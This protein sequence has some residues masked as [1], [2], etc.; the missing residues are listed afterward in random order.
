MWIKKRILDHKYFFGILGFL[1]FYEFIVVGQC[2]LWRVG[3]IGYAFHAVD[4]E[5]GFASGILPGAIY[6]FLM[7]PITEARVSGYLMV[8]YILFFAVVAFL[9]E[10]WIKTVD[11]KNRNLAW[12]FMFLFTTGPSTFSVYVTELGILEFYWVLFALLFFL[13]LSFRPLQF[14]IVPLCVLELLVNF[15]AIICIIPFF[16][17]LILFKLA[18]EKKKSSRA[19]LL[20]TFV[21]CVAVAIPTAVYLILCVPKNM[22]Y[23]Y[24]E[25]NRI[26]GSRGVTFPYYLDSLFYRYRDDFTGELSMVFPN[27]GSVQYSGGWN[28]FVY[29]LRQF[30]SIV[31]LDSARTPLMILGPYL[32]VIP[33]VGFMDAVFF[34]GLKDRRNTGLKRFAYFCMIALFPFTVVCAAF[35]SFDYYK[36]LSFAFLP[37]ISAFLFVLYYDK[38]IVWNYV[39]CIFRTMPDSFLWLYGGVYAIVVFP[40]YF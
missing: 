31:H 16:C 7:G 6:Q 9:L 24:D 3:Q 38:Q 36:W 30:F 19:L 28:Y 39:E 12:F 13:F 33:F 27:V 21:F 2:E 20:I 15:S 4:Y 17:I 5:F 8:L 35:L 22:V 14:L 1:F 26:M 29:L 23:P 10:K 37:T 40:A 18:D 11:K 34:A 32:L 25:F